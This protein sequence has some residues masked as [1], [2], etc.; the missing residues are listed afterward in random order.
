MQVELNKSQ[1][2]ALNALRGPPEDVH[3]MIMCSTRTATGGRIE[4]SQQ[5]LDQLVAF[6][7]EQIAYGMVSASAARALTSLCVKIDPNCADWLGM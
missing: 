1:Y 2:R 3:M 6:V 5:T 4:G 7:N